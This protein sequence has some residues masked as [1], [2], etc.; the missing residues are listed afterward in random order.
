MIVRIRA[1]ALAS[2]AMVLLPAAPAF[3]QQAPPAG[4]RPVLAE[5]VEAIVNDEVISTV[6]VRSRAIALLI[7]QRLPL[8][9]EYL[10]QARVAALQSLIDDHLKLQ[11]AK[12][13]EVT[14]R[15]DEV[16]AELR[17]RL[18]ASG[19]SLDSVQRELAKQGVSLSTLRDQIHADIAWTRI[20]SGRYGS[21]VRISDTQV[22]ERMGRVMSN[23]AKEQLLVSELTVPFE[24]APDR[25]NLRQQMAAL[26]EQLRTVPAEQRQR[27]FSLA[28]RQYSASP[29]AAAGGSL[30]WVIAGDLR[31]D[32]EEA[33]QQGRPGELFGPIET[34]D[35]FH[36]LGLWDRQPGINMA[37][38]SRVT[39][40]EVVAPPAQR[41]ALDKLRKKIRGCEGLD[42]VVQA[43]Q[44]ARV[45]EIGGVMQADLQED[46]L[47]RITPLE[48][49]AA[50]DVFDLEGQPATLVVC[51]RD[52][53]AEELPSM[54]EVEDGLVET[55]LSLIAQRYLRNLR[56]D[57]TILTP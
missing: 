57:S 24:A 37:E 44:G 8:D 42:G 34:K 13:W 51:Q 26:A 9:E 2:A 17:R 31:S 28:A 56:Q 25:A 47:A 36:I 46:V 19:G 50:S 11:E 10:E 12:R 14:V 52:A 3:A 45:V 5:G 6:D 55:E 54:E 18:G 41:L 40:K 15:P 1:V 43:V 38:V 21:R 20:I 39:L 16:D 30:G 29:T 7:G 53:V 4:E 22:H 33:L 49:G 32:F 23:A 35:G 27:L 48:L